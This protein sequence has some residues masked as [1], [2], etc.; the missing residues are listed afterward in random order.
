[1]SRTAEW[2][3][4]EI[5]NAE[6]LWGRVQV[7]CSQTCALALFTVQISPNWVTKTAF[8]GRLEREGCQ[9]WSQCLAFALGGGQPSQTTGLFAAESM[10]FW[11]R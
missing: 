4:Q 3:L 5:N 6:A 11:P 8:G 1:M 9:V 7:G 2:C 10:W